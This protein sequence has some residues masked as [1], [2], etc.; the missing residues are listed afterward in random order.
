MRSAI[1]AY[2]RSWRDIFPTTF[3]MRVQRKKKEAKKKESR[4][5]WKLPQPWKSAKVACGDFFLMISTAAWKSLRKKRSGFSTVTTGPTANNN[6]PES[7]SV[8]VSHGWGAVQ[9]MFNSKF[10]I[11]SRKNR[12]CVCG[13]LRG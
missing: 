3:G 2:K 1:V 10:S 6:Q 9:P 11:L 8:S 12:S 5:L 4:G 13:S 7:L